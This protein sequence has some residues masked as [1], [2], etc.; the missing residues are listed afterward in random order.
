MGLLTLVEDRPTPK[1][2]YNWRVYAAASV[3]SWASCTIG[4]GEFV[5]TVKGEKTV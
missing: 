5:P 4:Y 3:A 1:Q 2:V